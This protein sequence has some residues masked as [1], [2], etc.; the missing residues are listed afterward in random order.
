MTMILTLLSALATAGNPA[1]VANQVRGEYIEA[2]TADVYTGPC[3]ANGEVFLTG[4]QGVVAWKVTEG[5]WDGE[6]LDG[7]SIAAAV[8]GNTTF[9]KDNP[10]KA[11]AVLIVDE[12][13][14]DAQRSALIAMA[15]ELADGRLDDVAE[16]VTSKLSVNVEDLDAMGDHSESVH[17]G[18]RM[19]MA[20][21]GAFYAPGL[22]EITTRPLDETD[23][24]CGNEVVEYPPLSKG[25]DAEPAYT[26]AHAFKGQGLNN[27]WD[28]PNCRS[29]FVGF[30]EFAE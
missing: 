11:R 20:P 17:F 22:A 8:L 6:S 26:L 12:Q 24:I 23:C 10:A 29:S 25:V 1:P 4:H 15:R 13:A 7:L 18:M 5:T 3:F 9:S 21:Q 16:V 14:S 2:R 19:P 27:R 30:F 28:D